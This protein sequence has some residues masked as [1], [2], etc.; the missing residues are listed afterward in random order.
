M[1]TEKGTVESLED[2]WAWVSTRRKEACG[3]CR[4]RNHCHTVQGMDRMIVK[5]KNAAQARKG[6]QVELYVSTRTKLKGLFLLYMFPVIGLLVGALSSHSLSGLFGMN[7]NVGMAL[8]T[9]AGF[10]AALLLARFVAGRMET[11][12]ELTPMVSRVLRRAPS[13]LALREMPLEP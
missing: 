1:S 7:E 8:F 5:A 12:E 10:A 4:Q 3:H 9:S 6:D 13:N 11:R 2:G